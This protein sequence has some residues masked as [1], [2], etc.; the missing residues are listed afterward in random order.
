MYRMYIYDNE[1]ETKENEIE[2]GTNNLIFT[3]QTFYYFEASCL[4]MDALCNFPGHQNICQM[5][6]QLCVIL[7]AKVSWYSTHKS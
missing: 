7:C 4:A 5:A 6:I 1:F 2:L 3:L